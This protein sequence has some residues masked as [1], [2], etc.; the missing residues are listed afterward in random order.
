MPRSRGRLLASGRAAGTFAR[1]TREAGDSATS[2]LVSGMGRSENLSHRVWPCG[3]GLADLIPAGWCGRRYRKRFRACPSAFGS[4]LAGPGRQEAGT[5]IS[6]WRV[7]C[8]RGRPLVICE[9][10]L[11]RKL[12]LF[13]LSSARKKAGGKKTIACPTGCQ[14]QRFAVPCGEATGDVD[15]SPG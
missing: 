3:R 15:L 8:R 7:H 6:M 9:R 4:G 13:V 12:S 5:G 14:L 10:I 2:G 1:L 11:R